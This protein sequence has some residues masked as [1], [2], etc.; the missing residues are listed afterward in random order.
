[1]PS[2]HA[3][4]ALVGL[5]TSALLLSLTAACGSG[6]NDD[7]T[8]GDT[9]QG[10]AELTFWSWAPNIEKVVEKVNG[11]HPNIHVTVS[12]Q[13]QGD[14]LLTKVL[15][16]NKVG[17]PPDLIQAEYQALPTLVSNGVLADI[18]KEAGAAK[19]K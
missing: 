1:M 6:G 19:T 3:I 16:W 14:D 18:R 7:T 9:P 15:T 8:A 10:K 11:A 17:N 13:A 2:T 12:K 4:K 5:A